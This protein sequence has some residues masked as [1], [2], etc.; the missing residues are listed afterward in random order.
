MTHLKRRVRFCRHQKPSGAECVAT[1]R[2]PPETP[3]RKCLTAAAI[4][5]ATA[6]PSWTQTARC[7]G[8]SDTSGGCPPPMT[9]SELESARRLEPSRLSAIP[10]PSIRRDR[11]S[12]SGGG[13][14][15]NPTSEFNSLRRADRLQPDSTGSISGKAAPSSAGRASG[16]AGAIGTGGATSTGA[17]T[18]TGGAATSTGGS[19]NGGSSSS[20]Q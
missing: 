20:G 10:V 16:T 14:V 17:R 2:I 7:Q 11:P 15:D 4:L 12:S 6:A 13:F 19:A 3:M 1:T 8:G 18:S 5:I 9:N